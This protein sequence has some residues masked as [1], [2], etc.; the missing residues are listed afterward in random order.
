MAN[1]TSANLRQ[2]RKIQTKN[3]R[4]VIKN[5]MINDAKSCGGEVHTR[6]DILCM[7]LSHKTLQGHFARQVSNVWI[8]QRHDRHNGIQ[9]TSAGCRRL[10]IKPDL[11]T[12]FTARCRLG[13]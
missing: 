10:P 1:K 9:T 2:A 11:L 4:R 6:R 8:P 3:D 13:Q 7:S 12:L 5:D